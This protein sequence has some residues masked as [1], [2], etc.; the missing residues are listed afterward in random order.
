METFLFSD[1]PTVTLSMNPPMPDCKYDVLIGGPEGTPARFANV[2]D[3]VYHKW[4]C[5]NDMQGK[6]WVEANKLKWLWW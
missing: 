5:K 3:K 4:N 6:R 2:G 1:I